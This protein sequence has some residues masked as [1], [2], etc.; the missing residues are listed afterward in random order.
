M[1]VPTS[2]YDAK[3]AI[4]ATDAPDIFDRARRAHIRDRAAPRFATASFLYARMADEMLD[5]LADIKRDFA[6]I[7]IVGV[8]DRRLVDALAREGRTVTAVDPGARN[9]AAVGGVHAD[10]DALPFDV[11]SFD[12]ILCC[13]TLDSVGDLPGAL[14]QMRRLLKP[15]GL[16][17]ASFPGAGSLPLLKRALLIGDGERPAQRIHPQVDVRA[18][19]DLLGR[20]GF[21]LPVADVETLTVRYGD[22]FALMADLRAMGATNC[23]AS[24]PPPLTRA[25][26]MRAASAFQAEADVDGRVSERF[27]IIHLSGWKPDPGQPKPARR[28]SGT[29]SLAAA[30]K[31]RSRNI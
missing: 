29:T 30:L 12:L 22:M 21:A 4:M 23:L 2:S 9:A 7:L 15:D 18:A 25:A 8:P 17:L 10:E 24:S 16:L 19:G 1:D 11:D 3:S 5:R 13:G 31:D 26:L 6:A 14:I 20:A 28:G 27:V